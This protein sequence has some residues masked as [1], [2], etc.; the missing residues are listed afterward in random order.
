MIMS[1]SIKFEVDRVAISIQDPVSLQ[2]VGFTLQV[3]LQVHASPSPVYQKTTI[4]AI[5][6]SRAQECQYIIML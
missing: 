6:F 1:T 4:A 3:P 2:R 5:D